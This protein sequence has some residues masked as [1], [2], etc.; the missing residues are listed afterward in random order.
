VS[1]TH[2][3][4]EYIMALKAPGITPPPAPVPPPTA[5]AIQGMQ[6]MPGFMKSVGPSAAPTP[7]A[8]ASWMATGHQSA[9]VAAQDHAEYLRRKEEQGKAF[10]FW[11]EVGESASITF[12]DGDLLQTPSGLFLLP[13]RYFEH[14]LQLQGRWGNHFVCTEKTLPGKGY[15]CPICAGG[16]RPTLVALFTIIDHRQFEGKEGKVYKDSRKLFVANPGSF[17]Q[18][19]MLAQKVQG[20]AGTTWDVS[21]AG[22]KS[23]RTGNN[24]FPTG[25]TDIDTLTQQFMYEHKDPKT[26]VV[27]QMTKFTPLDYEQ[28]IIFRSDEEL[29]KLGLGKAGGAPSGFANAKH[30]ALPQGQSY[31]E[32][33]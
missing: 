25:K 27:T 1:E 7:V 20:L 31:G 3:S 21:R 6:P 12:V 17:E 33:L 13:P 24:F 8:Q 22:E 23:P 11:L 10:R 28:E 2:H 32:Q 29:M 30:Q 15:K 9:Q 16:D 19:N 26:N 18:L 14:N 5:P 4:L